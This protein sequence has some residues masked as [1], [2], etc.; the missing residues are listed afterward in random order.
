M[1]HAM[2]DAALRQAEL[3]AS[4]RALP[5]GE[6]LV[7]AATLSLDPARASDLAAIVGAALPLEEIDAT[8]GDAAA[9]A[10]ELLASRARDDASPTTRR[11]VLPESLRL[12]VFLGLARANA[13]IER[14]WD[15]LLPYDAGAR[16]AQVRECLEALP[17]TRR[18][19]AVI[20]AAE[21]VHPAWAESYLLGLLVEVPE[22]PVLKALR[23]R[24]GVARPKHA[25]EQSLVSLAAEHPAIAAL[26]T[27]DPKKVGRAPRPPARLTFTKIATPRVQELD[28][29]VR[30]QLGA[31][32]ETATRDGDDE[33]PRR[34]DRFE[35]RDEKGR[36]VYDVLLLSGDD[37]PVYRA[38]TTRRVA[39]FAQGG[40][41]DGS[42][43]PKLA[44]ALTLAM[45]E[46]RSDRAARSPRASTSDDGC[47]IG[48]THD[49]GPNRFGAPS[50]NS[51]RAP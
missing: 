7:A 47:V 20:G 26:L 6:R 31:M 1:T 22:A 44:A 49:P 11:G 19:A 41:E 50:P 4:L 33:L 16:L 46:W 48:L 38:G 10:A 8:V 43:P 36:H 39:Y 37:G 15:L 45:H 28:P 9:R 25:L 17:A 18:A 3:L 12:A 2:E 42:A 34:I 35:V 21:R 30:R 14:S 23:R 27:L 40:V 5:L 29:L 51:R 13:P 24:A 32:L